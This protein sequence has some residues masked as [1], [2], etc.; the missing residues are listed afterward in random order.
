MVLLRGVLKSLDVSE[1]EIE[2]EEDVRP[3]VQALCH[4]LLRHLSLLRNTLTMDAVRLQTCMRLCCVP[5]WSVCVYVWRR[6]CVDVCVLTPQTMYI[7]SCAPA[8]TALSTLLVER[9]PESLSLQ[10]AHELWLALQA[11]PTLTDV[12]TVSELHTPTHTHHT[13]PHTLLTSLRTH[14]HTHYTAPPAT[15]AP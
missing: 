2:T 14:T 12:G 1:C 10:L 6:V 15:H 4:S 8:F 13:T 5:V 11:N 7:F 9:P 3:L